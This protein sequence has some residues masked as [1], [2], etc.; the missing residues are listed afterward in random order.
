MSRV[1]KRLALV[2]GVASGAAATIIE[3]HRYSPVALALW[4]TSLVLTAFSFHERRPPGSEAGAGALDRW[5]LAAMGGLLI[6]FAPLYLYLLYWIPFP[7]NS[8]EVVIG[9]EAKNALTN[10]KEDVLGTSRYFGVAAGVFTLIGRL[11]Q[12][13]GGVNLANMRLVHALFGLSIIIP[14]Y[15]L[16]RLGFSRSRAITATAI[17]MSNHALI[18]ISRMISRNNLAPLT[19][20]IAFYFLL[21]GVRRGSRFDLFVGG[22]VAGLGFYHYAPARVIFFLWVGYLAVAVVVGRVRRWSPG[23]SVSPVLAALIGGFGFVTA[24]APIV[25]ATRRSEPSIYSRQQLLIYPEGREHQRK[26]YHLPSVA[27]G[28]AHNVRQGALMFNSKIV[29]QAWMYGNTRSGFLDPLSGALLW[30]GVVAAA[31][32]VLKK[33]QAADFHLLALMSFVTLHLLYT[34]VMNQAPNY[35][36]LLLVLPAIA[37]LV[38]LALDTMASVVCRIATRVRRSVSWTPAQVV[39]VL[40]VPIVGWNLHI[41]SSYAIRTLLEG[42]EIGSTARYIGAR[43]E[44]S[45]Y[46][47]YLVAD[48]QHRYYFWGEGWSHSDRHR[49][50]IAPGQTAADLPPSDFL[51]RLGD[52]PFT[53]LM[54]RDLWQASA[55]AFRARFPRLHPHL[56][57]PDGSLLGVE[58]LSR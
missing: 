47:F 55:A 57:K 33:Q 7:M 28:M 51:S 35:T 38:T 40:V 17:L 36:R 52:P 2:L 49:F 20:V 6:L 32:A 10:S 14:A 13:L 37:H 29:D 56:I 48:K 26:W 27:A 39:L 30:L 1:V 24:V 12:L 15:A 43:K 50:F 4:V 21:R 41:F 9:T 44:R 54:N 11:G 19:L 3:A 34:F 31:V 23:W 25:V 5:D 18:A 53:V 22:A 42:E 8:D 46:T 45:P 16:F 58:V